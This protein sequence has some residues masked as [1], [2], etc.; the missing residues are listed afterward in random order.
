MCTPYLLCSRLR[1]C[2]YLHYL[3]DCTFL[4]LRIR[5]SGDQ[6][7]P[8][9]SIAIATAY[10]SRYR[11]ATSTIKSI[12]AAITTATALTTLSVLRN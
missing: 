6:L 1:Q 2:A 8:L 10:V 12:A 9:H 3:K 7:P 5:S 4:P 11:L